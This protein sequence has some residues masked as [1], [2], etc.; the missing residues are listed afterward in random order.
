MAIDYACSLDP[1]ILGLAGHGSEM[2]GSLR[3]VLFSELEW[4]VR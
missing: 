3:L 4:V 2:E 1:A